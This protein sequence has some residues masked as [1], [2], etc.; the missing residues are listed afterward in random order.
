MASQSNPYYHHRQIWLQK[1]DPEIRI[2][3]IEA[4]PTSGSRKGTILLIHGFPETSYQFRHVIKP[5]SD[6]GYHVIA[7][8]YRGAGYSSHPYNGYTKDILSQDLHELVTN[9]IGVKEKIHIVGH[10]IGG[11]IAHAYV[12]QYPDDVATIIWGECPLP[13]TQVYESNK[14]TSTLWHFHFHNQIDIPELLVQGKERIYIKHFYDRLSMNPESFSND[15]LDFYASQYSMPGALRCGF[16]VYRMFEVDAVHNQRWL[17]DLGKIRVKS[18]ILN[19][20]Q[21]F[22]ASEAVAMA[23]EMYEDVTEGLIERSGHWLAEENPEDFV[24]K[25]LGFIEG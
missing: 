16:N 5:L 11:M 7:P 23:K 12:A 2:H 4:L 3:Y 13:G 15:D 6:A 17:K 21:S 25:V 9:H 8:D 14:F 10:D 22:I 19:G 24:N 1:S 20:D 18:M